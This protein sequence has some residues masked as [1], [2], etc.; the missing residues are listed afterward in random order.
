MSRSSSTR[1]SA[2]RPAPDVD[3]DHE[4][5]RRRRAGDR[6]PAGWLSRLRGALK[7]PLRLRRRGLQWHIELVDRRRNPPH[8]GPALARTCAELRARLAALDREHV[9]ETMRPLV[10][11]YEELRRRGWPGVEVMSARQLGRAARQARMLD[12]VEPSPVLQRLAERL[13]LAQAAAEAR[14][15]R[16]RS[17]QL[18]AATSGP[19]VHETDFAEF[20]R[21]DSASPA[22]AGD[23]GTDADET[24]TAR[25]DGDRSPV[26]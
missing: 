24:P 3:P 5:D 17:V 12:E 20:E 25:S 13:R 16:A 22:T 6:G 18:Q 9:M 4:V 23:A 11:V 10:R 26:G 1:D 2:Q 19:E 21:A 8:H 7:R 14:E 15:E